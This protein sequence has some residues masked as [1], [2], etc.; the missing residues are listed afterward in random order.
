MVSKM[1]SDWLQLDALPKRY[2]IKFLLQHVPYE[3]ICHI[4]KE[5]PALFSE[6]YQARQVNNIYLDSPSL[7]S[8]EDNLIGHS[9]R[10]LFGL[11]KAF[12][13]HQATLPI[14]EQ[15][16]DAGQKPRPPRIRHDPVRGDVSAAKPDDRI[17]QQVCRKCPVV[18]ATRGIGE[19]QLRRVVVDVSAHDLCP[20]GR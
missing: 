16:H 4:I 19:I 17:R 13:P 1:L 11:W 15:A 7:K 3:E 20:N 5:N 14:Q 6:I 18:R 12:S 10:L 8:Y 9:Q 2:E